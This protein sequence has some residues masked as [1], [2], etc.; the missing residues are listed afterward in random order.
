MRRRTFLTALGAT[1][2]TALSGAGAASSQELLATDGTIRPLAF[3]STASLLDGNERPLTDDSLVAV[4]AESTAYNGDADGNGDAVSYPDGTPIPLVASD[5]GIVGFG[6]PIGQDDTDFNY[7]NE[8]FLLNVLDAEA[9][10]PT[11]VF[12]E[13]HGQFYDTEKFSAF[14]GYAEANGYEIA[15]TTDIAADLTGAD[16]AIVTSPSEVFSAAERDA[17]VAFVANGGTLLLFDQSDFNNF[18]ATANLNAIAEAIGTGFRFNDDQVYD[19]ENNLYAPFVPLTSNFNTAFDYFADREGLGFELDPS[20]TY[21]VEV[22]EVTDGDT[23]DVRFEGGQETAIRVLGIDTPETGSATSTE[24]AEEWEGIESYDYLEAA[25]N[26]AT[27]FARGELSPGQRVDLSFDANEPARDEFGRVLGY[28]TYDADG[29]GSRETLYNH[30][31]I[32]AGH[33]RVYDSGLARHDEFL[34]AE[35]DARETGRNVWSASDPANA[36]SIRNDPVEELFVPRAAAIESASGDLSG[37]VPVR[38]EATASTPNAPLIAVDDDAGIA[39]VGSPFVDEAYEIAEGYPVETN[40]YGNYVFLTHLLSRT[41][42][43][44][45]RGPPLHAGPPD[46]P[47]NGGPPPHA[48]P[49]DRAGPPERNASDEYGEAP[50]LIDGGHGQFA[51]SYALSAEDAAYYLRYLEGVDIAF[52]GVNQL[53]TGFGAE[54]LGNGRALLITAP[55]EAY[56]ETELDAVRTFRKDGGAVVLLGGAVPEVAR[57]NLNTIAEAL[58]SDLRLGGAVTDGT[59]N[60]NGNPSVPITTNF[61]DRFNLFDTYT[62]ETEYG[63][64]KAG[65]GRSHRKGRRNDS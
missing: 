28:L 41:A 46:T 36:E 10:G 59:N 47:G 29:S 14:I 49:P 52:E 22:V 44:A 42:A 53:A 48:G 35:L 61:G 17:L 3:D 21:T 8:E 64:R 43:T 2:A 39:M 15:A 9:D 7:G 27:A 58:G 57:T 24:R 26:A 51:A 6:A 40:G 32:D 33:A 56:T 23:V 30:R 25:G 60:L 65:S 19:P 50:V 63:N 55:T 62:N 34:A 11:V 5:D 4:W 16:A 20:K 38:A 1:S 31:V 45:G 18:D 13:G 12:D 37:R 54:L